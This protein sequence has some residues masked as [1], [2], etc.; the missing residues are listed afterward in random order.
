VFGVVFI[1]QATGLLIALSLAAAVAEA[2]PGLTDVGWSVG[3][4]I[5]GTM[6][7]M[8]LYHGL[9]VGRMGVVAPVTGVLAALV[10]VVVGG[11]TEGLP[12]ATVAAGIGLAVMAVVL[13]SRSPDPGGA[14]SGIEFGLIA[15]I[16][17]G[18]FNVLIS[19]VTDGLVFGP[20]TI[21]RGVEA[22][23]IGLAVL[24]SRTAWRPP[25][26][27]VPAIAVVGGLDMAGNA[28]FV[29][30]AQAGRL[31]VAAVLSSLYPVAT[32]ILAAVVLH[33]RVTRRHAIGIGAALAAIALIAS[34]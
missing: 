19:R 5:A 6:G 7:I 29:L 1:S 20:L 15:G 16:G 8:A 17:L 23:L 22:L 12:S 18:L 9:A 27:V 32:V 26:A 21:V 14:R 10:P 11:A 34:G 30:A 4:G 33:E 25:R 3:A 31:D 28:F 2:V 24:A 13:V